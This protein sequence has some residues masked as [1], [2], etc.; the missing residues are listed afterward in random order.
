MAPPKHPSKRSRTPALAQNVHQS[1]GQFARNTPRAISSRPGNAAFQGDAFQGDAFQSTPLGSPPA[2]LHAE[3]IGR[4]SGAGTAE[5]VGASVA[6]GIGIASGTDA[7]AA[8]AAAVFSGEG[9]LP[10]D[11]LVAVPIV[12]THYPAEP[13]A[14]T[15]VVQSYITIT[16]SAALSEFNSKITEVCDLLRRSNEISGETRDKLVAEMAAGMALLKSPKPDPKMIQ[17][18]LR[19]TLVYIAEKGS[20]AI[21]GAVAVSALALLGKLT[22]LW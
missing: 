10:A 2:L 14:G 6:G 12:P 7:A 3:G 16:D 5:A 20:G 21:I 9:T 1:E 15:I 8:Q 22:G 13:T 19:R 4:A 18:L 11:A 17:L